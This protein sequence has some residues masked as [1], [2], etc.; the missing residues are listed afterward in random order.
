M[1]SE[2]CSAN[3]ESHNIYPSHPN[4]T[5][6]LCDDPGLG[7]TITV[8][9][10]ILR[11]FGLSTKATAEASSSE[12]DD[13]LFY[14]YWSSSF[15]TVHVRRPA[16]LKLI[17]LAIK[18]DGYSTLFELPIEHFLKEKSTLADYR[19]KISEP[20]CL[21]DLRYKYDKNDCSDFKT[22]ESEVRLCFSNA[23]MYYPPD[24]VA[25][26][27]AERMLKKF[28]DLLSEFKIQ[29]LADATKSLSRMKKDSNARSLV[30]AFEAKKREELEEPLVPSSSTLLV[31]PSSLLDHWEEQMLMHI[32]FSYISSRNKSL[33]YY[34]TSKKS[35]KAVKS[36]N[37]NITLK[38][39]NVTNPII[40]IDDGSKELPSEDV[41]ARFPIVLTSYNRFT[42]DWK[43]GS[44]EQEIRASR[45]SSSGSV[46]WGE[47]ATEASPLLKVHWLR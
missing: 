5:R 4:L 14:S 30:D 33:I 32:D 7:K 16:I 17:N 35:T 23:M 15:L 47:E 25:Y 8:L 1:Q 11:S 21:R 42:S 39:K 13:N 18:S 26:Q 19:E 29:Q 27:A 12:D 34:H 36:S 44:V 3:N 43:N 24:N 2:I 9:S 41:L 31:V 6:L 20:I 10:L 45:G 28:E 37:P 46:Y 40:F 22:F 38:L